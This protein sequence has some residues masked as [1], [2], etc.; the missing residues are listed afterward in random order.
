MLLQLV[1]Q[2]MNTNHNW[3]LRS[4]FYIFGICNWFTY[5]VPYVETLEYRVSK[6][7]MQSWSLGNG[8][9]WRAPLW[10]WAWIPKPLKLQRLR[11]AMCNRL[12]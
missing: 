12:R 5:C 3:I 8:E 9:G 11:Y 10:Q 7:L 2:I 1:D 4:T 6:V